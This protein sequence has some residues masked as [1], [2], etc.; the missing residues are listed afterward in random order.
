MLARRRLVASPAIRA[1]LL[2]I[3]ALTQAFAYEA[4]TAQTQVVLPLQGLHYIGT[5]P[6]EVL[7]DLNHLAVIPRG[8]TTADRHPA[9]GDVVSLVV[10]P[11]AELLDEACR[12][13]D[14][15]SREFGGACSFT[16][17]LSAEAQLHAA[18]LAATASGRPGWGDSAME[19]I[20][21]SVLRSALSRSA[22]G[23]AAIAGRSLALVRR[24]RELLAAADEPLSVSRIAREVGAS[25]TYLTDLFRK[26]EGM[27]IYR[28]QMRLRLARALAELPHADDITGLALDLGFSSHSHFSSVF[29]AVF[30]ISPSGY[31]E[32]TR[33]RI[34]RMV[35][36][37]DIARA[38]LRSPVAAH[39]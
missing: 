38:P 16:R 28:Y 15:P 8:L 24:V 9:T 31:R 22:G 13:D 5:G 3:R 23:S 19:E 14:A 6:R 33:R 11:D 29:K 2:E 34:V 35:P 27:P 10:T 1:D 37:N 26:V 18:R 25:P 17:P 30:K 12:G 7:L 21:I 32:C 4:H 39:R 20:L 36:A